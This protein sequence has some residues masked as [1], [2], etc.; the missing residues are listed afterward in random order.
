MGT[1]YEGVSIH[2]LLSKTRHYFS[3]NRLEELPVLCQVVKTHAVH[4]H[5]VVC[6]A[7]GWH[8]AEC[9]TSRV[10]LQHHATVVTSTGVTI[11]GSKFPPTVSKH[12][13]HQHSATHKTIPTV[14]NTKNP[15]CCDIQ[16]VASSVQ[17]HGS[18]C[19]Q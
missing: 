9:R 6:S 7:T 19:A 4:F 16:G 11:C 5:C 3:A 8:S 12:C 14:C 17:Y 15:S 13:Q 1:N 10:C 2:K 18:L